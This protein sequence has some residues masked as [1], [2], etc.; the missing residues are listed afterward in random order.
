MSDPVCVGDNNNIMQAAENGE[1]RIRASLASLKLVE[2]DLRDACDYARF[3]F[4]THRVDSGGQFYFPRS[5]VVIDFTFGE[6][7][8]S[9]G[10][11]LLSGVLLQVV[12]LFVHAA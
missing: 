5:K 11:R 12:K 3:R 1:E 8:R 6:F 2:I 9:R 10:G 4:E 7:R